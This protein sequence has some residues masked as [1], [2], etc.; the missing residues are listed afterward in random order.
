MAK[1]VQSGMSVGG[2]SILLIF[3]L[4]SLTTFAALSLVS[5]NADYK[6]SDKNAQATQAYYTADAAAEETLAAVD[7]AVR[8]VPAG[9]DHALYFEDCARSLAL[10]DGVFAQGSVLGVD[11]NY[12][13]PSGET[14]ELQVA[15][16]FYLRDDNTLGR[17]VTSWKMAS[18]VGTE[19]VEESELKIWDG[20][21][22][23]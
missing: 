19:M 21:L 2:S 18:I 13:I 15:L 1:R 5:A 4:L 17:R 16:Q 7:A 3:V 8:G 12:A 10:I 14:R 23:G 20:K 11:V 9:D 22:P 6:L